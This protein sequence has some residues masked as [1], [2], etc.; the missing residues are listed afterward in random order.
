MEM[1]L[2]ENTIPLDLISSNQLVKVE[3]GI[4]AIIEGV[5]LSKL[6]LC[7]ALA[8]VKRKQLYKQANLQSFKE[9]L[10]AKRIKLKY[11][12]AHDYAQI[13]E[14]YI[15]Y[16]R[17]LGKVKFREECGLKKLLL[18][19]DALQ[20]DKTDTV[21]TKLKNSSYRDFRRYI[22]G[23]RIKSARADFRLH[24]KNTDFRLKEDEECIVLMPIDQEVIWFND[25]LLKGIL[26]KALY[27]KFKKY[28][29]DSVYCFLRDIGTAS[30]ENEDKIGRPLRLLGMSKV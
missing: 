19:K 9:Y 17:E 27:K 28:I 24:L 30:T 25:D 4:N 23:K 26:T 20:N 11:Q 18:L 10:K 2:E 29:F 3:E 14:V 15:R 16:R 8:N 6:V 13:G 7:I 1:I 22:A 5:V 21:F 12:T